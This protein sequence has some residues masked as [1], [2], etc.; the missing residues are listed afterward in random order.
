[1][2]PLVFDAFSRL[3]AVSLLW[4]LSLTLWDIG[5]HPPVRLV[6]QTLRRRPQ[7]AS[8]LP[9]V[10]RFALGLIAA[11][12]ALRLLGGAL[13]FESRLFSAYA[14]GTFLAALAVD[15]LIGDD[16]R[17]IVGIKK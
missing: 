16:L 4:V 10:L 14:I 2:S 9:G 12:V 17:Q 11:F 7:G 5:R 13:V 15:L 6:G 1:M 3:V 8:V